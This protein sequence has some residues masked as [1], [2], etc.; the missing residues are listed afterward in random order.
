M[1]EVKEQCKDCFHFQVCANVLKQQLFIR[2]VVLKEE[3]P[4]CEHFILATDVIVT[5]CVAMVEQ[6]IKDGKFDKKRTSHNG[7]FAVVY[8]D[9][10]KS[11]YTLIDITE[12]FYNAEK[13]EERIQALKGAEM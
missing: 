7:K 13:A 6:F 12:Q 10:S 5:P 2:E 1:I 8:K 3:T 4:K 11:S 9:K